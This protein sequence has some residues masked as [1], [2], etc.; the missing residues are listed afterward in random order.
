MES[1]KR[2]P[3]ILFESL[4]VKMVILGFLGLLLLIPLELVREVIKERAKYADEARAEIDKSWALPQT[5]TG[6]VL[7]VPGMKTTENGLNVITTTLHIMPENLNIR[8]SMTPETRYRGIYET[9]I[10]RA[11]VEMSGNFNLNGTDGFEGYIYDWNQA[12]LT[13][14]VTDNKGL[15]GEITL[16][17]GV[18]DLQAE[19]GTVQKDVFGSG[20]SFPAGVSGKNTELLQEAFSMKF[21]LN[22]SEALFFSP[23]G[24]T[25]KVN[26]TS[27]WPSPSFGGNFLP[28]ERNVSGEGFHASWEVTHLNRKFPQLWN[29][30]GF[31]PESDAFGVNLML[32][33]DHYRKAERSAKYGILFILLTFFVLILIE[34]RSSER[35]HIF[36]YLL[37]AGALILFF[38]LLSALSEHI[39][40]NPAYLVA[41]AATIA[42][43]SYFFNSLLGKRWVVLL[44]AGLLT[45]LYLFVFILLALKDYAYLAGNIGLFVLLAILMIVSARY[46]IFRT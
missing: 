33:V 40:F 35:I 3:E 4:T 8:A 21:D 31:S 44:V 32:E 27:P 10:Y 13:L 16:R 9:V 46:R 41:S 29:G 7:N 11:A 22:G 5:L 34:V 38:S 15:C 25:T 39:G 19:P 18:R 2:F 45:T 12:Y 20:I 42:L 24:K 36:Y 1:N 6:P 43:L 17:L 28:G 23:A 14:G 26:I 30:G 37:V